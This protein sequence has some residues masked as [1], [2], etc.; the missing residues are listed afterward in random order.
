MKFNYELG[1]PI[2]LIEHQNRKG[3]IIRNGKDGLWFQWD[4]E[5]GT[6]EEHWLKDYEHEIMPDT[7]EAH[8]QYAET[9]KKI[10]AKVDEATT[11][12]EQ[13]FKAWHQAHAIQM[14]MSEGEE[15]QAYERAYGFRSNPG[16]DL[17]KFEGVV[18]ANGWSTSSL[19]C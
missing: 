12:L 2:C 6:K 13:A 18:E 8:A 16:L 7:P 14:G 15:S 10:Q 11:L 17:S 19:Y 1:M 3:T 9:T 4:K 5:A